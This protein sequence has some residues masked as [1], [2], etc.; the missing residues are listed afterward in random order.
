MIFRGL[1]EDRFGKALFSQHMKSVSGDND[2]K[3]AKPVRLYNVLFPIFILVSVPSPL[4]LILI[5]LN[6]LW[7]NFIL[8]KSLKDLPALEL[9]CSRNSWKICLAG[10]LSD[11]AGGAFLFLVM[12]FADKLSPDFSDRIGYGLS[13]DPF[14]NTESFLTTLAA[15]A[16][17]ALLIYVTDRAI[18]KRAGLDSS[19][20]SRAARNLA[21]L[22]APWLFFIPSKWIYR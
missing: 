18:L 3:R 17:S 21:F 19:S 14:Y 20:A 13:M 1:S 8:S 6:Y 16:L 9:F 22:T 5:P 12:I 7:D 4:W 10:F 11:I 15:V 2:L